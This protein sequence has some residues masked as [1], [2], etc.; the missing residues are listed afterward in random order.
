ME[1]GRLVL[2]VYLQV[3][4]SVRLC[5]V[6]DMRRDEERWDRYICVAKLARGR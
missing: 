2:F 6:E 3:A 5:L 4:L 1:Q